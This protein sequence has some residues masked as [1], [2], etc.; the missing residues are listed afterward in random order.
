MTSSPSIFAV[1]ALVLLLGTSSAQLST[2][3]YASSCPSL[4]STVKSAVQSAIDNERRMGASLLRLFFHDCFVNGCDGS[5]LLDDTSSFMG[6]KTAN[7]NNNSVRGFDVVD[8]IKTAVENAC[9]G[10]VSCADILAITARDSVLGGPSWDVKLGRRDSRTA[11]LSTANRNIPPPTSSL[12]NLTSSFANQGLSTRDLVA[13]SGAHT[14][15]QARCTSFRSRIYNDT[16]IDSSFA[17]T[18][19]SNCPRT[20]GSGDNGLAPLDL[21]TPTAFDN[22]YYANLVSQKGLL[23]TDQELYNGGSTDSQVSSYSSSQS[24]F[25]SDFTAAMI[26]MGDISPLTGSD[27]EIRKNCRRRSQQREERYFWETANFTFPSLLPLIH[28]QATPP[29]IGAPRFLDPCSPRSC[30]GR[31]EASDERNVPPESALDLL[32]SHCG[33]FLPPQKPQDPAGP[34]RGRGI[35]KGEARQ[36]PSD[37]QLG[38][39]DVRRHGEWEVPVEDNGAC[40][41]RR[42][43]ESLIVIVYVG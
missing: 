33:W 14:I 21:Q 1:L 4:L 2:N 30:V 5:I 19:Q 35:P 31:S 8:S 17:Q 16:N 9:S 28:L 15:G 41:R 34:Q 6:E 38:L 42:G 26:R 11:S 36:G 7:P 24:S 37:D 22:D 10:V 3:F 32:L 39:L 18:R 12:S 23:H 27:G 13:L 25:F 20:S 29:R 40:C 43:E